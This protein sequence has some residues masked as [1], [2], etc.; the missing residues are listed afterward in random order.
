V[1]RRDIPSER[2]GARP[3]DKVKVANGPIP[4]PEIEY[5]LTCRIRILNVL[6]DICSSVLCTPLIFRGY[7]TQSTSMACVGVL[8]LDNEDGVLCK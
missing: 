5:I 7:T 2:P 4:S 3:S 6:S 1:F 8:S